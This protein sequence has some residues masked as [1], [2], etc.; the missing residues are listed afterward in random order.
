M[1]VLIHFIHYMMWFKHAKNCSDGYVTCDIQKVSRRNEKL[2]IL[3]PKTIL[4]A[5]LFSLLG[6]VGLHSVSVC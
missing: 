6:C 1:S 4:I 5:C 3:S 2:D